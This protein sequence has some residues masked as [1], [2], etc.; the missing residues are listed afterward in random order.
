MN[1]SALKKIFSPDP[2]QIP[3][4]EAYVALVNQARK[5]FFYQECA[6]ADTLDGRFDVIVLHIFMLTQCL[7]SESP[8]FIRAVWEVFF[9][10]M[11]R[12]LRE[13]GASD[14]GIGKRVK[15]MAQAFYGRIDA[16]EKTAANKD[17][18]KESLAR[19]LYRGAEVEE[20]QLSSLISYVLRNLEY[21]KKQDAGQ[22]T[23][24]ELSFC[25]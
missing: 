7:K 24:G 23:K 4:H 19:N 6:V 12:S 5:P 1:F 20:M 13:M 11:D 15:K 9:S 14:T 22:I 18:F 10:D 2:F 16:Y 21:L 25:D 8:E 3:A 17:E